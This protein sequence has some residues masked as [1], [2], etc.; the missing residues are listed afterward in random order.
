MRNK[1]GGTGG[2][3][4]GGRAVG[5]GRKGFPTRGPATYN[6]GGSGR[7]RNQ[8]AIRGKSVQKAEDARFKSTGI[9]T[10]ATSKKAKNV[11]AKA[12]KRMGAEGPKRS[13]PVKR[14]K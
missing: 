14:K 6:S 7:G 12:A 13:A 5:T 9:P 3:V 2:R 8:S 1:V 11:A 4:G 10:R